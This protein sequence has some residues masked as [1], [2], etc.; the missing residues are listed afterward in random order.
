MK[1]RNY[2]IQFL[3]LIL[4]FISTSCLYIET[5]REAIFN[6][7]PDEICS[8]ISVLKIQPLTEWESNNFDKDETNDNLF[9][10]MAKE[11][12][13]NELV[14]L[15]GNCNDVML[16]DLAIKD[17]EINFVTR[18]EKSLPATS[19]M[20]ENLSLYYDK[21]NS[22]RY[23]KCEEEEK[24]AIKIDVRLGKYIKIQDLKEISVKMILSNNGEFME[25]NRV[26]NIKKVKNKRTV[27]PQ[28]IMEIQRR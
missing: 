16:P 24:T 8:Q 9:F 28:I 11:E 23:K 6:N 5:H 4:S 21:N 22:I 13:F 3:I 14:L 12:S 15:I 25:V 19:Y 10:E 20:L 18:D 27:L 1:F 2:F 7:I 17:I 26:Y